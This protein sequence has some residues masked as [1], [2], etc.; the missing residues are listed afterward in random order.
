RFQ[1]AAGNGV[2]ALYS[3]L[4]GR[5]SIRN[6]TIAAPYPA[7]RRPG[8]SSPAAG[9][10]R[11]IHIHTGGAFTPAV[12]IVDQPELTGDFSWSTGRSFKLSLKRSAAHSS[13]RTIRGMTRRAACTTA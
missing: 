5:R 13:S 8:L 1:A 6:R 4:S 3:V 10:S 11:S 12:D 7:G 9:L 2:I